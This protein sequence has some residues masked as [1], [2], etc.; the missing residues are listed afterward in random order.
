MSG[1]FLV[2]R[3]LGV[4]TSPNYPLGPPLVAPGDAI[5]AGG[6]WVFPE[7]VRPVAG[8]VHAGA[9]GHHVRRAARTVA[10]ARADVRLYVLAGGHPVHAQHQPLPHHAARPPPPGCG[11]PRYASLGRVRHPYLTRKPEGRRTETRPDFTK[12]SLLYG[13]NPYLAEITG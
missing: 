10:A 1:L 8:P 12:S 13:G 2:L 7:R 3:P 5:V 9:L 11:A 4:F 6:G